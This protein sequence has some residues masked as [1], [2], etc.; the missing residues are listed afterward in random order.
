MSLSVL[1]VSQTLSPKEV[2]VAH[3]YLSATRNAVVRTVANLSIDQATF[4][5]APGQWSIADVVEHLNA[6]EDL[7][8]NRIVARL[9]EAP[10]TPPTEDADTR[11]ARV[12]GLE[13]NPS[14]RIVE[15]GR[16]SL[17]EAP[18]ATRPTGRHTIDESLERFV[19][20]RE[21][22]IRVLQSVPNLREYV[23]DHRGFGPLDGYQWL[24]F[25]AAHT[26]RHL[27]QIETLKADAQFPESALRNL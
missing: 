13:R 21:R 17:A 1:E 6:L 7:F 14:T 19:A 8:V 3:R 27:R 2:E 12:I 5:R 11:D 26:E 9:L 25:I 24:L 4:V 15:Y 18:P 16:E 23:F 20:N 10:G 22:T